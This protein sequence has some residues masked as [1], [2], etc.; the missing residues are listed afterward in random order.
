M[1]WKVKLNIRINSR[2]V[3]LEQVDTSEFKY[4]PRYIYGDSVV[5]LTVLVLNAIVTA[6]HVKYIELYSI[7]VQ[8][9]ICARKSEEQPPMWNSPH[10]RPKEILHPGCNKDIET[11]DKTMASFIY[12]PCYFGTE[13]VQLDYY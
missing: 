13:S 11:K 4:I 2:C 10:G 7:D 8:G 12:I 9:L 5:L 1:R 3:H 6:L